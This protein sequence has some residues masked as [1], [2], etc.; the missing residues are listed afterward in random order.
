M[1]TPFALLLVPALVLAQE[2]P[3]PALSFNKVHHAFGR[4]P[5]DRKVAFR[6]KATNGGQAPLQIKQVVPS[7]GC[8]YTMMGQ[9]H[10]KPGE[11]TELEATFDPKGMRGL[12]R[13][14][15]Q[16]VSD[17]P[18]NPVI[19]LSFEAEVIQEI[20]PSTTVVFFDAVPRSATRKTTLRL[21]SGN[22]Q[23]VQVLD[24]KAAGAPYLTAT[25]RQEGKD[26]VLEVVFDARK[27]PASRNFWTDTL[28]VRTTSE[29]MGTI[30]IQVQWQ[31][32][33]AVVSTPGAVAWVEAAGTDLRKTV[34]LKQVDGKPFRVLGA[35]ATS[36]LVRVE[37]L[38]Q[39]AA[40]QQEVVV[41]LSK[42]AK[43][44]RYSERLTLTLDDPE[45][46]ELELRVSA[47]L[48]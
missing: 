44:G 11:S 4:I 45:Q 3:K 20:M 12:V 25:P 18:V 47:A 24:A 14:S 16:V 5:A 35:K 6:F 8:T 33:P 39:A 17:D 7:C 28:T 36:P 13:K 42:D 31:L 9:W 46:P 41:V 21:D 15:M 34:Q 40:P 43:A 1:R 22:G 10:L 27:V 48:R 23:P 26:V 37:G 29:R 30:P 19:T 38:G 2:A 32:R